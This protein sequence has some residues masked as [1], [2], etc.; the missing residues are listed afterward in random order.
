MWTQHPQSLLLNRHAHLHST[1][2]NLQCLDTEVYSNSGYTGRCEDSIGVPSYY[3][4]LTHTSIAN[5]NYLEE[6]VV[7][8]FHEQCCEL[9]FVLSR[10]GCSAPLLFSLRSRGDKN[11]KVTTPISLHIARFMTAAFREVVYFFS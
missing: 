10:T 8:C 1:R 9:S 11:C 6:V 7:L 3:A 4:G 2:P 5:Q